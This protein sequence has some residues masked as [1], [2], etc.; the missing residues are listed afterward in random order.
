MNILNLST[1]LLGWIGLLVASTGML[2]VCLVK[3]LLGI[4]WV[5]ESRAIWLGMRVVLGVG[6]IFSVEVTH[7]DIRWLDIIPWREI[8][9]VLRP[10]PEALALLQLLVRPLAWLELAQIMI[11]RIGRLLLRAELSQLFQTLLDHLFRRLR[12]SVESL[13]VVIRARLV[14]RRVLAQV[15]HLRGVIPLFDCAV[16]LRLLDWRRKISD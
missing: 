2:M 10:V 15:T 5:L 6:R 16:L 9:I 12:R 1:H 4:T 13:V 11:L 14:G 7:I 3:I 8:V